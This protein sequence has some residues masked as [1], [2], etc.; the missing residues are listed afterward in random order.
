MI[1]KVTPS[2]STA[3]QAM[4]ANDCRKIFCNCSRRLMPA[5]PDS[6]KITF[7]SRRW[8][9][10]D[11]PCPGAAALTA[12][13]KPKERAMAPSMRSMGVPSCVPLVKYTPRSSTELS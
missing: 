13:V 6:A 7:F 11:L 9:K 10:Y 12:E 1:R 3:T 5:S 8:M 4:Y 2:T